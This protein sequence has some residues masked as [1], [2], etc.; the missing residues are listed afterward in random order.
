M[1]IASQ[2]KI[3]NLSVPEGAEVTNTSEDGTLVQVRSGQRSRKINF[4]WR[5]R[6]MMKP[7]LLYA[8]N[9]KT[10]EVACVASLVPTFEP[11]AP[12]EDLEVLHDEEPDMTQLAPGSDFHFVFVVD[13]SGSMGGAG[14]M[15]A[16][17]SALKIFMR[18][19]PADCLFS[20]CSFGT[21]FT[22]MTCPSGGSSMEIPYTESTKDEALA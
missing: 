8:K 19:L 14:R 17:K 2:S 21:R 12:Q 9:A 7:H 15:D 1:S 5:T 18:S 16:A 13:R 4:Y 6:D 10:S 11:P 22:W 20:I 3:S